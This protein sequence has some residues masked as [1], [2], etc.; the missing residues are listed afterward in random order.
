MGYSHYW[1]YLSLATHDQKEI[2]IKEIKILCNELNYRLSINYKNQE[3]DYKPEYSCYKDAIINTDEII[4]N[5]I[6]GEYE[7]SESF[8]LNFN[9][10]KLFSHCK[11][12]RSEKY[13]LM[14][15]LIILS[16]ANNI[17][18]FTF[19]SD[20]NIEDWLEAFNIY[21]QYI[22]KINIRFDK[23]NVDTSHFFA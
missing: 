11:T 18:N 17:D 1:G 13:D 15:C 5:T 21:K 7:G 8:Y 10:I 9:T 2:I 3:D 14:V 6:D 4:F 23:L 19:S 22:G 20:G 16:L 12:N